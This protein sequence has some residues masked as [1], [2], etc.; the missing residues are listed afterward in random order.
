MHNSALSLVVALSL[1]A[2]FA[3]IFSS[4]KEE[5]NPRTEVI[6]TSEIHPVYVNIDTPPDRYVRQGLD[7]NPDFEVCETFKDKCEPVAYFPGE[8]ENNFPLNAFPIY[9]VVPWNGTGINEL[10]KQMRGLV[11]FNRVIGPDKIEGP[12]FDN[13]YGQWG[14]ILLKNEVALINLPY[15]EHDRSLKIALGQN[16]R[17]IEW[18]RR[19]L[20]D[21]RAIIFKPKN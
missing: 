14:A 3:S 12:C 10:L 5:L 1:V 8:L 13:E 16:W 6:R 18:L 17:D 11:I 19:L 20:M 7:K 9:L 21:D 15:V 2:R 4:K